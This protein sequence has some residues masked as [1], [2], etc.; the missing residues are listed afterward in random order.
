MGPNKTHIYKFLYIFKK[1]LKMLNFTTPQNADHIIVSISGGKD[2]AV[3]LDYAIRNFPKEKLI[4]VHAVIDI[5]WKE[6]L[7]IVKEQCEFFGIPLYLVQAVDKDGNKKGFIDQML[8]P[9][10]NRKTGLTSH[11]MFP[12]SG[13][14][15]CTSVLKT[16]PIDKFA[17]TLKGNVLVLIGE[18]R[19][20][21][22]NRAKLEAWRPD[23]AN[24]KKDGSRLVVKYSPILDLL[25]TEVW[26]II[27]TKNIPTHPCYENFG[28]SRASC[29]ICIF[30]SDKDI[31]QASI[32]APE[33]V[34]KYVQ[35]ERQ[36]PH[37]FRYKKPTKKKAAQFET[38]EDILKKMDAWNNVNHLIETPNSFA[39]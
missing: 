15:F 34:A 35:M 32:H 10:V 19:E 17:R 4:A 21:S 18:R 23:K 6:T 26:N 11:Y 33:I 2:S 1:G 12:D 36:I 25:E 5:D 14:R 37:T 30:S 16:G 24:S 31:K 8:A 9:R 22:S 38:I 27:K 20:E 13:N 39:V 29:A 7:P 3:L 28:V